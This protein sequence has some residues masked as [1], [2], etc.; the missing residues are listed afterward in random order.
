MTVEKGAL[1][2]LC[3]KNRFVPSAHI[4]V[5]NKLEALGRSFTCIKSGRSIDPC[6]T[7]HV[8]FCSFVLLSLLMQMYRFLF[9]R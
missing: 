8:T 3:L 1:L 4:I 5:F 7:P 2:S 6:D 9:L